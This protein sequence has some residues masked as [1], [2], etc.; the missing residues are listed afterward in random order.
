[1]GHRYVTEFQVYQ[2]EQAI[3]FI[4]QDFF[5]KE[6]F[7]LVEYQG[8]MVWKKGVGVLTAPQFM[9][10]LYSQGWIHLEAWLKYAILPGVYC[11]EMGL[12]GF[13]GFA[14]KEQLRTR[15]RQLMT[16][17]QQPY[18]RPSTNPAG[19]IPQ[20]E[21]PFSGNP[22]DS[23]AASAANGNNVSSQPPIQSVPQPPNPVMVH[24]PTTQATVALVIGLVSI[25]A[26]IFPIAGIILTIVGIIMAAQGMKSTAKNRAI[27]GLVLS[28]IF[29]SIS[30]IAFV[31]NLIQSFALLY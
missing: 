21:Q 7:S 11:G 2:P 15:V 24:N 16:L 19:N 23:A 6:G 18:Y 25:I 8:E 3:S 27:A 22:V 20:Q 17:L 14:I 9:R 10:V 5:Q 12:D 28:I 31:I 26:W 1:M 30:V 29:L 4:I 13:F